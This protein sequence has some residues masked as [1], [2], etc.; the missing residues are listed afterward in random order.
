MFRSRW[1]ASGPVLMGRGGEGVLATRCVRRRPVPPAARR[2]RWDVQGRRQP[3]SL[4]RVRGHVRLGGGWPGRARVGSGCRGREG[5]RGRGTE[6]QEEM[7]AG[8][9]A[10]CAGSHRGWAG[11]SGAT[12]ALPCRHRLHA[13]EQTRWSAWTRRGWVSRSHAIGLFF[14]HPGA[15]S[16]SRHPHPPPPAAGARLIPTTPRPQCR[17]MSDHR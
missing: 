3:V 2:G 15:P 16:Q 1:R 17:Y 8:M 6:G 9:R 12:A 14:L 7:W 4:T 5:G 11:A 13:G 10:G